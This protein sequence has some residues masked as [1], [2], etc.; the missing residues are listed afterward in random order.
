MI[1]IAFHVD[2]EITPE[3]RRIRE[4]LSPQQLMVRETALGHYFADT[5]EKTIKQ[6]A[7]RSR[8]GLRW[9]RRK[10]KY[11]HPPL[12][13]TKAMATGWHVKRDSD[14]VY[15]ENAMHYAPY[16]H[17][18]TSTIPARPFATFHKEDLRAARY[19][20]ERS[21]FRKISRREGKWNVVWNKYGKGIR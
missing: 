14:R 21:I 5:F 1:H 13:K 17:F 2:D 7:V 19:F 15:L 20:F 12:L 10:R 9:K 3:L 16:Q 4:A 18:G 6:S 8:R 11:P